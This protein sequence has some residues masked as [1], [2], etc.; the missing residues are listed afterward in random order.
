MG[1]TDKQIQIL[2]VA[3]ELFAA[4]GYEGTSV[5]D[6]AEA[7]GINVA[8]ISYYFGSKEKLMETLFEQRTF[9][10]RLRIEELLKDDTLDPL[11]KVYLL[12]DDYIARLTTSEQFHKIMV[13]EMIVN[14]SPFITRIV[15]ELKR[16]NTEVISLLIKD[17]QEKRVFRKDV[18]VMMMMSTMFGTITQIL[19]GK[20]HYREINGLGS[21]SDAA[22]REELTARLAKHIKTVFKALL[23][24]EV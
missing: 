12:V 13:C 8:M 17:G 15:A 4:K 22:F 18:D 1:I 5:R 7:A 24:Y 23:T 16:K 14:K 6:I 11:A 3:E 21:M 20:E 2:G 19:I 9:R 10:V